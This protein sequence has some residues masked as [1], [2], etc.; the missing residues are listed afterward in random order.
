LSARLPIRALLAAVLLA[1]ACTRTPRVPIPM[2]PV[3]LA[4]Y[5][6]TWYEIARLPAFFQR[7]CVASRAEY[8]LLPS[9]KIGV[10]NSCRT[11]NGAERS[12]RGEAEVVDRTT[13]ARLLVRFDDWYSIFMPAPSAGNYWILDVAADYQ[14]ALVATPDRKHLWLLARSPEAGVERYP[15]MVARAREMG[16]PVEKLVRDDWSSRQAAA[17]P[18]D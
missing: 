10:T 4:G 16:F 8:A 2:M 5:T 15:G 18:H 9:G 17:T 6:G 14:T 7:D 13:N 1:S 11:R 3:D 12:V